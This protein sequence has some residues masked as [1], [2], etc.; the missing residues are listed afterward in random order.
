MRVWVLFK[1]SVLVGFL[2]HCS[3]RGNTAPL[4]PGRGRSPGSPLDL[5]WQSDGQGRQ[6]QPWHDLC[7]G[8]GWGW[9]PWI[10][11]CLLWHLGRKEVQA[12]HMVF[13]GTAGRGRDPLPAARNDRLFSLHG[14][15]NRY[16]SRVAGCLLTPWW[17][18]KST[19]PVDFA[20][21]GGVGATMCA[22]VVGSEVEQFYYLKTSRLARRSL[23][24]SFGYKE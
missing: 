3:S 9:R 19:Y 17:G 23:F 5:S 8:S 20:D 2:W 21:C 6:F 22:C 12:S 11:L 7:S 18:W 16:P 1:A 15:L 4:L 24:W 10:F 14:F 13:T